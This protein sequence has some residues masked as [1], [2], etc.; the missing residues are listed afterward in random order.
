MDL[1]Q[2]VGTLLPSL[3]P[4]GTEAVSVSR[5]DLNTLLEGLLANIFVDEEWYV[6]TYP[7]VS[8]AVEAGYFSSPTKHYRTV[9]FLEGRLPFE[10]DVDEDFYLTK[11]PD[12]REAIRQGRFRDAQQHFIKQGYREGRAARSPEP[13]SEVTS[14][15]GSSYFSRRSR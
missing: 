12:V 11:Y 15:A 10:P 1:P 14:T 4:R 9:G 3:K 8:G 13:Q 7:D 6:K 5:R 2:P